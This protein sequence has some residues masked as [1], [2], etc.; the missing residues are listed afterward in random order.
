MKKKYN[1]MVIIL[2]MFMSFCVIN[3]GVAQELTGK[4]IIERTESIETLNDLRG[5]MEMRIINKSGKTRERE[6]TIIGLENEEGVDKS[7]IRFLKP[8]KVKGTGFLTI[9][10]PDGPDESYLYLPA[11]GKPRRLSSEERG[12]NFMG[13]DFT[14]ED[15]S[16]SL[17]DYD[18]K[19]LDI[20]EVDGVAHYV[21]ESVPGT[22]KMRQDVGFAKRLTW[23]SKDKFQ[24]LKMEILDVN[25]KLI[26]VLN[27][28][29]YQEVEKDAWIPTILE[30]KTIES[31]SRTIL[32][33]KNIEVNTGLT[34][35]DFTIRQLTR[36][37]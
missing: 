4:E 36:P 25:G 11:L 5:S 3:Q 33:Y 16:S 26:R 20:E 13:S 1:Y 10:N 29:R 17:E 23:V 35:E 19:L 8:S 32:E 14:N 28:S 18:H 2:M 24:V 21:V 30:M 31:G 34:D 6:L 9:S 27:Y 12:G 22:E 7:L 15:M 37:L